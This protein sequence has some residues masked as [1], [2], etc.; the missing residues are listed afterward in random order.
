MSC[1][2]NKHEGISLAGY[3]IGK[4]SRTHL[5]LLSVSERDYLMMHYE[6]VSFCFLWW[7]RNSRPVV[8]AFTWL[9]YSRD[10]FSSLSVFLPCH[11]KEPPH[12]SVLMTTLL[13]APSPSQDAA[14]A[15]GGSSADLLHWTTATTMK[16]LSN[17][18]TTTRAV[19]Q[20]VSDGQ[21]WR[22]S[23]TYLRPLQASTAA[24]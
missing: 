4:K 9:C 12:H 7:V 3:S 23:L 8:L 11:S 5:Y 17:T 22:K 24:F 14:G 19:L 1:Q 20:A 10:G 18:T 6:V 16:V 2:R 21:W 15:P 13:S